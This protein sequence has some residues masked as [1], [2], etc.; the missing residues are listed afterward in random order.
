MHTHTCPKCNIE[1][2]CE[3]RKMYANDPPTCLYPAE[4]QIVCVICEEQII[5]GERG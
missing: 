2:V 5:R 1:Y 3:G 4:Q